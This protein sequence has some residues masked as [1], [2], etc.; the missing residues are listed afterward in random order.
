MVV[1]IAHRSSAV[2]RSGRY[3]SAN[4]GDPGGLSATS[5]F[6]VTVEEPG[7]PA[8]ALFDSLMVEFT[9]K[10]GIGA[11]A[12]GIMKDGEIVYDRAF[13]WMDRDRTIPIRQDVMMRLASVTKPITGGGDP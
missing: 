9:E 1:A 13:G 7:Q 2:N 12:L 3:R 11:A 4:Q 5:E 8:E 6:A 10:H